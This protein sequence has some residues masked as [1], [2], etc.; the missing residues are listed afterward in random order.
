MAG[1]TDP[2]KGGVPLF[3]SLH[4]AG[5]SMESSLGH[6]GS[7]GAPPACAIVASLR[8]GNSTTA[9][10]SLNEV[11]Q[12]GNKC[13]RSLLILLKV[14]TISDAEGVA[15]AALAYRPVTIYADIQEA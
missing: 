6:R 5:G 4:V 2:A 15:Q 8:S 13:G 10:G 1:T 9:I 12:G 3:L 7:R 14:S 11:V